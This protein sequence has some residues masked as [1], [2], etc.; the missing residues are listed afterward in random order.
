VVSWCDGVM[1]SIAKS[2]VECFR[3]CASTSLKV[4]RK[5][6]WVFLTYFWAHGRGPAG[7]PHPLSRYPGGSRT[8]GGSRPLAGQTH[9]NNAQGLD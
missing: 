7:Y 5:Y 4:S 8:Y 9:P 2:A 6:H 1:G 3:R